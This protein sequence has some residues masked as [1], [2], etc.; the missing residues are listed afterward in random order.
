M[1]KE[2]FKNTVQKK[3]FFTFVIKR[4]VQFQIPTYHVHSNRKYA[5]PKIRTHTFMYFKSSCWNKTCKLLTCTIHS[6]EIRALWLMKWTIKMLQNLPYFIYMKTQSCYFRFSF[7]DTLFFSLM[8]ALFKNGAK[9]FFSKNTARGLWG[10][11]TNTHSP[12][13][14]LLLHFYQVLE[15]SVHVIVI[16]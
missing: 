12:Y 13:T 6:S 2:T 16:V 10:N 11:P 5:R 8:N 14:Y 15:D 3:T 1:W 9:K 4:T 7:R